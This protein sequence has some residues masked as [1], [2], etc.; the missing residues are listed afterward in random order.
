[1]TV[2]RRAGPF[3]VIRESGMKMERRADPR[4]EKELCGT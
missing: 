2:E 4:C 1:M 3:V